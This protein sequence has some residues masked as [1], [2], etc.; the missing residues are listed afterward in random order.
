MNT[1]IN[2]EEK[3]MNNIRIVYMGTPEL[4]ADILRGLIEN[5][6][7]IIALIAQQ[8][9]PVGRK[10]I[11][12]PVPTKK[13]AIEYNIPVYQ[14]L[15]IRNDFD[16]LYDLKP[17]LIITCAYGQIVPQGL[18]DIPR[19]G[20]INVHGSLLPK[21]RGASP[22][23]SA[24][25]NGEK[26]T[27]IT[28]MEMIDKMDAGAMLHKE[29]F[30]I[31][32]IDNYSSLCKKISNAGLKGLLIS[33]PKIIDGTINREEQIE[34]QATFCSKIKKENEHLD[35]NKSAA[36]LFNWIRGLS[37]NP[38]GYFLLDNN[39]LKVYQASVVDNDSLGNIGEIVQADKNGFIVQTGKGK[40]SFLQVQKQGKK[41]MD[42][43]SFIN[44]E[45]DLK[46]KV[47][48]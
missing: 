22:I 18:L 29:S 11:I 12:E 24:I 32:E 2:H 8:D 30:T 6:F 16:F 25:I 31:E 38:G 15:K 37:D 4:S 45:K 43:R 21:Y 26:E 5:G 40:I 33:L 35:I 19:L 42:Y 3:Q 34:E 14:P 17:D 36:E 9:K 44:G 7:N 47:L 13:V 1:N 48:N 27:G 39:V 41:K 46:G 23:Q 28:I 10:H 20:C